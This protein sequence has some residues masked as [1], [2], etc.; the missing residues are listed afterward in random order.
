MNKIY[1]LTYQTFPANTANSIQTVSMI[2]YLEKAGMS[3]ELVFPARNKNSS[4][5]LEKIKKY[6]DIDQNFTIQ[7][8]KHNLPFG[9]INILNKVFF[10]ISHFLWSKYAVNKI[11]A[12][13]RDSDIFITRS[14]WVFYFLSRKKRNVTFECH[15]VS[16]V[17]NFVINS[18][19]N[20][21]NS[22]IVFTTEK[23]KEHFAVNNK[24]IVLSNA[25]DQDLFTDF[26][27]IKRENKVVFVGS[28]LRFEKDRNINFL[29][30]SFRDPRLSNIT[31]E[32]IGGPNNYKDELIEVV[33]KLKIENIRLLGQLSRKET[34]RNMLS[35]KVGILI[36]SS[37]NSHSTLYTSPLK[38]FEYLGAELNIIAVDFP[39]HRSLPE[40]KDIDFFTE[41]DKESFINACLDSLNTAPRING[42][43]NKYSYEERVN[44]LLKFIKD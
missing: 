9:K 43:R 44:K 34:I 28:L 29:I 38:Y 23:L 19:K 16:K 22:K 1:Y 37:D 12:E 11:L 4:K 35:A 42:I 40:S 2:K 30:E 27:N 3:V 39:S 26:I 31:L 41:D 20:N 21:N 36:N 17:R 7:M 13:G 32:I 14:D 5:D 33:K 10:H 8:L 18:V 25:Y 15:Q 24:N 6:Y